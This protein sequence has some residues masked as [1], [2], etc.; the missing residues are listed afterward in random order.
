MAG[1]NG[2]IRFLRS[3]TADSSK[4]RSVMDGQPFYVKDTNRLYIGNNRLSTDG[5]A[6]S[7]VAPY[8]HA[9]TL[10][11]KGTYNYLDNITFE[12]LKIR[13]T[14][15][16]TSFRSDAIEFELVS[17]HAD[18]FYRQ[19]GNLWTETDLSKKLF[20]QRASGFFRHPTR[21][22]GSPAG[23][24]SLLTRQAIAGVIY[25]FDPA[26]KNVIG[27]PLF[28]CVY[29]A[30]SDPRQPAYSEGCMTYYPIEGY[31]LVPRDIWVDITQSYTV[32]TDYSGSGGST[33]T[34]A[35]V[36]DVVTENY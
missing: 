4:L 5:Q 22:T 12:M 27:Q 17:G 32:G 13:A 29:S 30:P 33:K 18:D 31:N 8:K 2:A 35:S 28:R 21:G 25:D 34:E 36:T 23:D 10:D 7:L 11:L 15:Y 26:R 6:I 1:N 16:C 24:E 19:W 9:L 14:I 20:V 3:N